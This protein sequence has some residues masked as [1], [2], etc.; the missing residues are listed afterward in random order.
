MMRALEAKD[1]FALSPVMPVVTLENAASAGPL[2]RALLAGGIKTLEIALRTPASLDAIR[3]AAAEAPELVVGAGTVLTEADLEAAIEA[4]ARYALSPGATPALLRAGR[5]APIPLAP[6]IATASEIMLGYEHGYTCFKFFPAEALGGP[7]A[8]KQLGAPL[9]S[10]RFCPTGGI[11][12]EAVS[13][14]LALP[15]VVCVGGSWVAPADKIA[16]GDWAAIES[17]AR[18]AASF[19]R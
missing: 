14:Y 12:P 13:K 3:V 9:A 5:G 16:A 15:N 19:A 2:A 11:G 17:L 18:K 4:G 1:V 8:L 10:A 6:G 7:S